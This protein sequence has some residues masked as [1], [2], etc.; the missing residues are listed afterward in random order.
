MSKTS[1][2]IAV[3]ES[4]PHRTSV[5]VQSREI[6]RL[7]QDQ[8]LFG[9]KPPELVRVS[10]STHSALLEYRNPASESEPPLLVKYIMVSSRPEIAAETVRRE[11]TAL[12]TARKMAGT[13]FNASIP[14]PLLALPEAGLIVTRKLNGVG[15]NHILWRNATW[16]QARL[17]TRELREIAFATGEWLGKFHRATRQADL[18]LNAAAFEREM[19]QQLERCQK[20]GFTASAARN[21]FETVSRC[22]RRVGD[23]SLPAASRHGDFTPRN[24]LLD[25]RQLRVLDFENFVNADFVYEDVGKFV[26]YVSLLHGRPGYSRSALTAFAQD[27]LQGYGTPLEQRMV[28]LFAMKAATRMM[29]HRGI[30]RIV[31]LFPFDWLYVRNFFRLCADTEAKFQPERSAQTAQVTNP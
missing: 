11:F 8:P 6:S 10:H 20:M 2:Q 7:L 22:L 27:F 16:P 26:A 1:P 3:L 30:R 19:Q 29:A 25:G 21:I 18:R 28:Q 12:E 23:V 24:I 13:D 15:L 9:G 14:E 5:E 4:F 17:R 31:L